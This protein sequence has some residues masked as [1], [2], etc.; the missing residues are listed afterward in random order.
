MLRWRG[1]SRTGPL[2]RYRQGHPADQREILRRVIAS[3]P[4]R[5]FPNRTYVSGPG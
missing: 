5:I 1:R 4:P 3:R 2:W